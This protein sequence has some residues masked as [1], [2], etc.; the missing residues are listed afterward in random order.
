MQ[1]ND[2]PRFIIF[3]YSENMYYDAV[4]SEDIPWAPSGLSII[5]N[6]NVEF[7]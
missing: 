2:I 1:E 4:A 3:D 6:L 5:E 7:E